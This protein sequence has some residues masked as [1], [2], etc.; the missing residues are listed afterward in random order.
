MFWVE[1]KITPIEADNAGR[2]T[3]WIGVQRDITQRR[4]AAQALLTTAQRLELALDGSSLGMW[5]IDRGNDISFRDARW[6]AMLGLPA[7]ESSA[8]VDDWLQWVHPDDIARV[9]AEVAEARTAGDAMFEKVFRMR[10]AAGRWVWIQSRGKVTERDAAGEPLVLAGTHMDITDKVEATLRIERQNAQLSRCLE[11]LNVGVVLLR[12]GI[13]KFANSTLLTIFG[14]ARLEDIVGKPFSNYILPGDI[15]AAAARQSQLNAGQSVSSFWFNCVHLDGSVFKALTSSTVIEWEGEHHILST[16]TPPGNIAMLAKEL[17]T[18]RNRY[19]VLLASQVEQEQ[20]RIAQEL[21]DCLGSQL[22]GIALHAATIKLESETGQ[23]VAKSMDD[24]LAD[25]KKAAV[26]TRDLARGLSPVDAWPGAFWRALE[27]LCFDFERTGGVRCNFSVEGDFDQVLPET[28]KHLYRIAQE[29]ITNALKHGCAKNI[30]VALSRQAGDM[31][32]RI[33]DDGLGFDA[34]SEFA[35]QG[36]GMGL[37]SMYARAR[38]IGAQI[39]L[40]RLG[41]GGLC[42]LVTWRAPE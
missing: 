19:E 42:V 21:H 29:A 16:M 5:T 30:T 26:M 34:P 22:A 18:T 15:V 38:T 12:Q 39:T 11:Q 25:I 23:S 31:K 32:L 14:G 40:D 8:G 27:Q 37:S 4:A 36:K 28:G 10:H 2:F 13:I 3:H 24:L 7:H 17:E 33:N 1:V 6:H 35:L 9:K 20:T 41:S